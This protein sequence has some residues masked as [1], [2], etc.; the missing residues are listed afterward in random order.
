MS[1]LKPCPKC[2]NCFSGSNQSPVYTENGFAL[3]C[4]WCEKTTLA[5]VENISL[6]LLNKIKAD[7]V[8]K[9]NNRI[10][11][12][13]IEITHPHISMKNGLVHISTRSLDE[14]AD[15]LKRGEL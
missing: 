5:G 15:K 1:E 3:K 11:T 8:R 14:Y 2:R 7:A 6:E 13:D 12:G 4:L 9:A 10:A